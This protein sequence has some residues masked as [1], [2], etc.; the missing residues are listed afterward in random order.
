LNQLLDKRKVDHLIDLAEQMIGGNDFIVEIG[1]IERGLRRARLEHRVPPLRLLSLILKV[2]KAN[3]YGFVK[4]RGDILTFSAVSYCTVAPTIP[5]NRYLSRRPS[6][7]S[8]DLRLESSH[9]ELRE[10]DI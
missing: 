9:L 5:F 1:A 4:T 7:L 10:V 8:F 2:I 6:I 3:F